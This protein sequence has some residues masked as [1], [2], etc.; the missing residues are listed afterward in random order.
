M[1]KINLLIFGQLTDD[2][3]SSKLE[4]E[5]IADTDTL[6]HILLHRYP[7]LKDRKFTIA[8]DAKLITTNTSLTD[9]STVALMP[10]FSGG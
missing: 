5:E 6:H 7:S 9:H 4:L 3:G 2:I 8:V 1:M 10:P